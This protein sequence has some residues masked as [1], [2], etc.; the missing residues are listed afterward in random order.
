MLLLKLSETELVCVHFYIYSIRL[1]YIIDICQ[2]AGMCGILVFNEGKWEKEKVLLCSS[3]FP[4][5]SDSQNV[6]I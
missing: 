3:F 2:Y 4:A 5:T 1:D 6:V